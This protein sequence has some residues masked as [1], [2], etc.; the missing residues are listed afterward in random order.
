MRRIYV[1]F[2]AGFDYIYRWRGAGL[3]DRPIHSGSIADLVVSVCRIMLS[4][5]RT[6]VR[7]VIRQCWYMRPNVRREGKR[8]NLKQTIPVC[9]CSPIDT[10]T[11]AIDDLPHSFK[12]AICRFYIYIFTRRDEYM[13]SETCVL[14][15]YIFNARKDNL[16]QARYLFAS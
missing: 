15:S 4:S 7:H 13:K 3:Q 11:N 6:R 16:I 10:R 12:S 1:G 8:E 14:L 5:C 9:V 2:D